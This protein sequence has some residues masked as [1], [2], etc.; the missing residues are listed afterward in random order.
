MMG[1]GIVT[2]CVALTS[3]MYSL[4]GAIS[5][6]NF[7][8]RN[9]DNFISPHY[10]EHGFVELNNNSNLSPVINSNICCFLP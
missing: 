2:Q 7:Y 6:I 5:V 10:C 9:E 4:S 1:T 8:L 3:L